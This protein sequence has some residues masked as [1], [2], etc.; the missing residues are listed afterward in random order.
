M[1]FEQVEKLAVPAEENTKFIPV[2]SL[3]EVAIHLRNSDETTIYEYFLVEIKKPKNRKVTPPPFSTKG[4]ALTRAEAMLAE[5]QK[6]LGATSEGASVRIAAESVKAAEAAPAAP[7]QASRAAT[8]RS[9]KADAE[10][11]SFLSENATLL[12]TAGEIEL[13]RNIYRAILKTGESS[14]VA[15][16]GLATC[17][18]KEGLVEQAIQYAWD[19]VAFAPNKRGY[20]L[21]SQLLVQQG[22]D[23][24]AAQALTRALKSLDLS[25]QEKAEYFKMIGNCMARLGQNVEAERAYKKALELSPASDEAQ[26]N[27]G[28]LHLEQGQV[29]DAKRCYQ[30]AIASNPGN[31][32]AWVGLG[33][34]FV[35]EGDK[36]S[37]HE[38]FSRS[39]EKNLRNSTAIFHLVKCAYEIK[40]YSQAEKILSSYVEIAPV[41][42]S[43][44]YSLAGLQ[45]HVGKKKEA[46]LTAK[47]IL[48]IKGD[49]QGARDL[50]KRI[51]SES[52]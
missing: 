52:A 18:D 23:Q 6:P 19:S 32:K 16:S 17:A 38:A 48:Q 41:S 21:L 24:E 25:I 4:D 33:L 35:S 37:A 30:D 10:E 1:M 3:E 9:A 28:S 27:L 31:D 47:R 15:Y 8:A 7:A 46:S 11:I 13:A 12:L 20:Q 44:L 49:H 34:C 5:T 36:E 50:L 39:L 29:S 22:R 40:K 43:L 2:S 26:S 51:E 42:P 14:D 45:F